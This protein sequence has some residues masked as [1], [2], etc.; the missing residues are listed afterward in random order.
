MQDRRSF[1]A[2]LGASLGSA[3]LT[4]AGLGCARP[5]RQETAQQETAQQDV[6][7]RD[8]T[9]GGLAPIGPIGVQLYT[10]RNEMEKDVAATLARVAQIGYKEV[11]FAGYFDRQPQEIRTLLTQNGLRAPAAHVPLE[12][13]RDQLAATL[14]A[15]KTIGHEYLIVPWLAEESRR[16]LDDYKRL[17]EA[18]TRAAEQARPAGIRVGYHNH[19]FEFQPIDGRIPYDVLLESTDAALVPMEL[20]LY[21]ITKTGNDPVAYFMKYP[22]RFHLVHVKDSAGAPAHTMTDVG[23][24]AINWKG[25][26]AHRAHAGIRH[27]FVEHDNPADPFASIE[28][29]YRYLSRL[30]V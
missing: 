27:Y 11:E 10:V 8:S 21:W 30:Q 9:P 26:F 12:V 18:L 23:R 14:D 24:G 3:A 6:A 7:R 25:L 16:T 1:L 17:G 15:A 29:S 22:G 4:A 5:A 19:D 13:V 2:T 20:D 28:T